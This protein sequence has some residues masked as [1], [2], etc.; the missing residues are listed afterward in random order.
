MIAEP[1]P[2][3]IE[4]AHIMID[5]A[6]GLVKLKVRLPFLFPAKSIARGIVAV[7]NSSRQNGYTE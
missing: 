4:T 6:R 1:S 3:L 7:V 5:A 2:R